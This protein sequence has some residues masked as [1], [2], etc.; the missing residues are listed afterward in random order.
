M[1]C[2]QPSAR[3]TPRSTAE[4]ACALVET[5]PDHRPAI[6]GQPPAPPARNHEHG[7]P[8]HIVLRV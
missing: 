1:S 2:D 7:P 4:M 8:P 5:Q 6:T 3:I